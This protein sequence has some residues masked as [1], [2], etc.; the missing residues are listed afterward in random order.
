MEKLKWILDSVRNIYI[1][2]YG[3]RGHNIYNI[4][5]ELEAEERY[6]IEIYDKE[7]DGKLIRHPIEVLEKNFDESLVVIAIDDIGISTRIKRMLA[8]GGGIQHI[9]GGYEFVQIYLPFM[10]AHYLNRV[11]LPSLQI[12][13]TGRCNLKCKNCTN[14]VPYY[15]PYHR[16][17][18]DICDDIDYLFTKVDFINE[19][20]I[21]GGETFLHENLKEIVVY[22][23]GHYR[24]KFGFLHIYTNGTIDISNNEELV[25]V[26]VRWK[27]STRVFI[28]D[29][30]NTNS[31]LKKKIDCF[32]KVLVKYEIPYSRNMHMQWSDVG[33]ISQEY[34]KR[35]NMQNFVRLCSQPC[36]DYENKKIYYCAVAKF[37][38]KALNIEDEN[39]ALYLEDVDNALEVYKFVSGAISDKIP[40]ICFFCNGYD[41]FSN[42]ITV[43]AGIQIKGDNEKI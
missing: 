37:G 23:C 15:K 6:N 19:L 5:T 27:E 9:I 13:I 3:E 2:G 20:P 38:A 17:L 8:I 16:S 14:F 28:S 36:R 25:T 31:D 11:F 39:N 12:S 4:L 22:L 32:E 30:S 34:V 41:V 21:L 1:Y 42:P 29:Y 43:D 7:Y 40:Q 24:N 35:N 33:I 10:A 18:K 26:L